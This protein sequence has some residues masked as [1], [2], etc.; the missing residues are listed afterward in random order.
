MSISGECINMSRSPKRSNITFWKISGADIL[1][2]RRLN[3]YLPNGVMNV[4]CRCDFSSSGICQNLA[5]VMS[6]E[7]T[8]L[9][10][11]FAKFSSTFYI[12]CISL[13]MALLSSV[14]STQTTATIHKHHSVWPFTISSF[15]FSVMAWPTDLAVVSITGFASGH[16]LIVYSILSLPKSQN[17]SCIQHG[18]LMMVSGMMLLGRRL[19]R[20][21]AGGCSHAL[22]FS[23]D[24]A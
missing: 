10:F 20:V 23:S 16:K 14:R 11:N 17:S 13:F 4:M 21:A 8:A 18:S 2:G 1:N 15:T 3:W 5:L 9:S 7:Y 22:L 12:G 24:D 6:L 19:R